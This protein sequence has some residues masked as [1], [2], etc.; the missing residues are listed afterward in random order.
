MGARR[1]F[2]VM[3]QGIQDKEQALTE[4][5]A[6]TVESRLSGVEVL[7]VELSGN[8]RF[9]VYLDRNGGV[10]LALCEQVSSLLREYG[11]EYTVEVSSPGAE[12]PLRKPDHFRGVVG[13]RVKL[14]TPGRKGLRGEVVAAGERAVTIRAVEGDV[15]VPYG[16]IVRANLIEEE[17]TR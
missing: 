9:T 17:G 5:V 6:E 15:E 2:F 11:R 8:D 12:R 4:A 13:R 3:T 14:R 10:D 16:E 7:A 1:P